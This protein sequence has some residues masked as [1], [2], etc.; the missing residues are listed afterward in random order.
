LG[1][2]IE[3]PETEKG[4]KEVMTSH[5]MLLLFAAM[6]PGFVVFLFGWFLLA[7]GKR[8]LGMLFAVTGLFFMI[9]GV[10]FDHNQEFHKTVMRHVQELRD[11]WRSFK[12]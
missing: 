1:W 7:R 9:A 5:Q 12:R 8:R 6:L 4:G 2:N 3:I 11:A 10:L